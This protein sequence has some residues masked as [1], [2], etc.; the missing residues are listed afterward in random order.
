MK[1]I[2]TIA[3]LI[4]VVIFASGVAAYGA[5]E[6]D[7]GSEASGQGVS[8]E[9]TGG[10]NDAGQATSAEGTATQNA[11]SEA[12][13]GQETTPRGAGGEAETNQGV[14]I[15]GGFESGASSQDRS[16]SP[17][18]AEAAG[19]VNINTASADLMKTV[20]G[21]DDSLA[22]NIVEYRQASGPFNSVDEL[23]RVQGV[24]KEKLDSIR[25]YLKV[26][27]ATTFD[28]EIAIPQQ[29]GPFPTY[30]TPSE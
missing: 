7:G 1:R 11:A 23:I 17:E 28:P 30:S 5:G 24:D 26:S 10:Q 12:V 6:A 3:G 20:P 9:G 16:I 19:T 4:F 18:R 21:I 2:T 27:G 25:D 29:R 14:G 15:G 13:G 22:N 8:T